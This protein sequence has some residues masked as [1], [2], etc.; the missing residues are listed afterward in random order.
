M[1]CKS[2]GWENPAGAQKC[3]KC[4]VPL[5]GS[6]VEQQPMAQPVQEGKLKSTVR[7][8]WSQPKHQ[9]GNYVCSCGYP[10]PNGE[11]VC[12]ACGTPVGGQQVQKKPVNNQPQGF[13]PQQQPIQ[14]PIGGQQNPNMGGTVIG[15]FAI[16]VAQAATDSFTIKPLPFQNEQVQYQPITFSGNNVILNRQ[17]TDPNNNTITSKEQAVI[18]HKK[19]GWYIDNRSAGKTTYIQVTRETKL[20]PGDIIVMGNR[21]FEFGK[22]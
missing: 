7:E 17:N 10:V 11:N 13:A 14:M 18:I 6:M 12:P 3:A 19:D 15:G 1:R 21:A 9:G 2:C 8:Q 16:G 22:L 4:N 5:E 20:K